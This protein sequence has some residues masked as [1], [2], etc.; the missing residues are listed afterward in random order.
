LD[1][2]IHCCFSFPSS[3]FIGRD[4]HKTDGKNYLNLYLLHFCFDAYVTTEKSAV[5]TS[6]YGPYTFSKIKDNDDD[7]KIDAITHF[8][9]RLDYSINGSSDF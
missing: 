2:I 1:H 6:N 8:N 5:T 7:N 3:K 9:M 4:E